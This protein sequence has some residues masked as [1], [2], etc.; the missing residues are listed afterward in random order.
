MLTDDENRPAKKSG[1]RKGKTEQDGKKAGP[2]RRKSAQRQEP[3]PDQL[4]EAAETIAAETIAAE[5][6]VAE[7]IAAETIATETIAA[8]TTA[9]ETIAAETIAAEAIAAET[10]AAEAIAEETVAAEVM[11]EETI[12]AETIAVEVMSTGD[13]PIDTSPAEAASVA[14]VAS[15]EADTVNYQTITNAYRKYAS[16]SLDQTKSF[17]ERLAGV[18][19]LD[20]AFELQTE[21]AK[22]AYDGFVAGSH[23]IREL[24]GE[25]TR[26][27]LKHWEGLL[28]RMIKPL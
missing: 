20:K 16:D 22:Q 8:E 19:S 9:A 18:R 23:R 6:I 28:A 25:L 13:A 11:V 26:Q 21:F 7:T 1:P 12:A 3:L 17:F 5:T 27:R 15:A 2:R 4:L 14:P 24:H 10:T